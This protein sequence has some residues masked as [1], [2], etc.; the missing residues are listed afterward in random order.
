MASQETI[1][2]I[3]QG[4]KRIFTMKVH[5]STFREVQNVI[6]TATEG[7]TDTADNLFQAIAS[8]DAGKSDATGDALKLLE[9]VTEQY[10]VPIRLAKDVLERGE[11]VS[12]LTSDTLNSTNQILLLN[13][14]LRIDG[15]ELQFIT[16]LPSTVNVLK[17]FIGRLTELGQSDAGQQ[18][19]APLRKDLEET[20]DL[21]DTL[22]ETAK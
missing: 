2:R 5:R 14:I 21:L 1:Q 4:L 10:A 20:S 15:T 22:T 8:G 9:K 12:L 3:D 19:L 13:R 7:D 11:F 17:H 18:A 6:L 16:D